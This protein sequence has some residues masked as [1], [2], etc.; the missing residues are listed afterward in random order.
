MNRYLGMTLAII[1]ACIAGCPEQ[2]TNA[3]ADLPSV[4]R[5][6][7]NTHLNA[8][9]KRAA[10]SDLGLSSDAINALLRDERTANQ[11][12]GDLRSAFNKVN[13][14]QLDELTPDEVQIYGDAASAADQAL[15]VTFSD[16][17][18]S[19]IAALFK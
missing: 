16:D 14:G 12:G 6:L 3:V 19:N 5:V 2:R 7:G 15:N 4:N 9:Q 1:I 17:A 18:G 13:R 10:L 11:G 8:Q